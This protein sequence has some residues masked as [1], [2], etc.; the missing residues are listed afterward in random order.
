MP[1]PVEVTWW[2]GTVPA[3]R[4]TLDL[5]DG[6]AWVLTPDG[7]GG[8]RAMLVGGHVVLEGDGLVR[9]PGGEWRFEGRVRGDWREL[10]ALARGLAWALAAIPP[11]FLYLGALAMALSTHNIAVPPQ[12][13][14]GHLVLLTRKPP[15]EPVRG[16]KEPDA[17]IGGGRPPGPDEPPKPAQ[18]A[19]TR[20]EPSRGARPTKDRSLDVSLASVA[21]GGGMGLV[22]VVTTRDGGHAGV[23]V[24]GV[25]VI[26]AAVGGLSGARGLGGGGGR[27]GSRRGPEVGTVAV[28]GPTSREP[29]RPPVR[30]SV[31]E[32]NARSRVCTVLPRLR[33]PLRVGRVE[34]SLAALRAACPDG[35]APAGL[36]WAGLQGALPRAAR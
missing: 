11:T 25:G 27:G 20:D 1:R 21:M 10:L 14:P 29:T 30:I 26:G 24:G 22:G 31:A 35:P 3:S 33:A 5:A 16:P 19:T 4:C 2:W 15:S 8:V 12:R 17:T 34:V 28:A 32:Q 23:Q 9:V 18:P 7:L 36:T 13:E 6:D